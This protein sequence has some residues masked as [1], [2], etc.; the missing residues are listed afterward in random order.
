MKGKLHKYYVIHNIIINIKNIKNMWVLF[1]T[2]Y[3]KRLNTNLLP[4][5]INTSDK[6]R[7]C[8]RVSMGEIRKHY[9]NKNYSISIKY[10]FVFEK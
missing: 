5:N 10:G 2:I 8:L 7:Y 1:Y 9:I 4:G 6:Y 3:L